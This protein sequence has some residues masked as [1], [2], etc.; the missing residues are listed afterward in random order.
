MPLYY[1]AYRAEGLPG[2]LGYFA[3]RWSEDRP[4]YPRWPDDPERPVRVLDPVA[5]ALI[6]WNDQD[7]VRIER[8]GTVSVPK[9]ERKLAR[10]LSQSGLRGH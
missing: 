1:A 4:D 3:G 2:G 8:W 7:S 6:D 9:D 5:S 10:Q